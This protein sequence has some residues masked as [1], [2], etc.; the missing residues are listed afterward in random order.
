MRILFAGGGTGG[1]LIPA[2]NIANTLR[3]RLDNAEF[4]FVGIKGGMEKSIV[5][6]NGFKIEE[7]EVVGLRRNLTGMMDFSKK[8]MRAFSQADKVVRG[9]GPEVVVG[10]GGYLSAPVVI[11]G[12]R[13][14]A[15]VLIQEQNIFPGLA[16]RF[17]ARFADK[18]C[19]AFDGSK[20]YLQGVRNIVITGNPLRNDLV[21]PRGNGFLNEFG[22]KSGKKVLFITGG[23]RGAKSLNEAMLKFIDDGNLPDNWQVLWQTGQDKHREVSNKLTD[24]DFAGVILPFIHSMPKAYAVA[25]FMVCRAG[26]MTLSELLVLGM[27]A[28]LVPFPH[29]TANHQMKNAMDLKNKGAVEVIADSEVKTERFTRILTGLIMDEAR[30]EKLSEN[31]INLGNVKGAEAISEEIIKLV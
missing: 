28:L 25:D 20:R 6:K 15:R 9:F 27:P 23:S 26:A 21:L 17:L 11:A 16:T 29:A 14:R 30:R 18:I 24:M 13:R 31:A 8:I 19:L 3:D 22:L 5:E 10:T 2:I 1:H 4:L 7:I 12:K